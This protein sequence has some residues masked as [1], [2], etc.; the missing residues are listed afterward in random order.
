MFKTSG[1]AAKAASEINGVLSVIDLN[2]PSTSCIAREICGTTGVIGH[3]PAVEF[4]SF[5]ELDGLTAALAQGGLSGAFDGVQAVVQRPNKG[6]AI[7]D[8]SLLF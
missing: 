7:L 2:T 5:R 8:F 1:E 3:A 6:P 4:G